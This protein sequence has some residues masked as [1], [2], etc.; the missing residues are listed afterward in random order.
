MDDLWKSFE[1]SNQVRAYVAG[2][3]NAIVLCSSGLTARDAFVAMGNLMDNYDE[4]LPISSSVYY[5]DDT[6]YITVVLSGYQG[7]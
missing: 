7:D 5:E 4:P 3:E 6:Y 1:E 2:K